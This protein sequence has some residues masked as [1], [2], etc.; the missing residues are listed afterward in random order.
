[1]YHNPTLACLLACMCI[2]SGCAMN[3]AQTHARQL[4]NGDFSYRYPESFRAGEPYHLARLI[5]IGKPAA[6][7]LMELLEDPTPTPFTYV[8]RMSFGGETL[9]VTNLTSVPSKHN[10]TVADL[11]DYALRRIYHKDIGFRSYLSPSERV[12]KI[13]EWK[14]IIEA[15]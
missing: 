9:R 6:S 11:A 5:S 4:K 15:R 3:E 10:A 7:V 12:A 8:G 1:M 14:G 2:M 13:S